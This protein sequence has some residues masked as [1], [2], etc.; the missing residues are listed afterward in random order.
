M[1]VM[2]M[3]H[4]IG[5]IDAKYVQ[6][7]ETYQKKH[8]KVIYKVLPAAACLVLLLGVGGYE[9]LY[10]DTSE[11]GEMGGGDRNQPGRPGRRGSHRG[12][13]TGWR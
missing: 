5:G 1:K 11:S 12:K 4:A 8:H 2:E 13:R 3:M 6:E 9:L 10:Q 7:A